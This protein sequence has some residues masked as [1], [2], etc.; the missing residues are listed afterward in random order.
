MS[1]K[2]STEKLKKVAGTLAAATRL[3][4]DAEKAI[5]EES[6]SVDVLRQE[7]ERLK[8]EHH[9]ATVAAE[10]RFKTALAEAVQKLRD[11][12]Y[13]RT[14]VLEAGVKDR[15]RAAIESLTAPDNSAIETAARDAEATVARHRA[16]VRPVLD[17]ARSVH[18]RLV[19]FEREHGDTLNSFLGMSRDDL[20]LGM[21]TV[22]LAAGASVRLVNQLVQNASG[23]RSLLDSAKS[24]YETY[25][26]DLERLVSTGWMRLG[27]QEFESALQEAMHYLRTGCNE[28]TLATL[29]AMTGSAVA[30]AEGIAAKKAEVAASGVTQPAIEFE[31]RGKIA[32]RLQKTRERRDP[33]HPANMPGQADVNYSPYR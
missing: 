32:E 26:R 24:T 6:M 2:K 8:Q 28:D 21:P 3:V 4:G 30:V 23:A 14:L 19:E 33:Q 25:S 27:P 1:E 18:D 12:E 15:A 29:V 22:G 17:A 10:E 31:D 16:R 20:L 9:E 13:R 11:A 5:A 7:L